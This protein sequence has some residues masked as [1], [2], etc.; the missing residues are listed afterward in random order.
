MQTHHLNEPHAFE[1]T[2]GLRIIFSTEADKTWVGPCKEYTYLVIL[3]YGYG[4][5]MELPDGNFPTPSYKTPA[6]RTPEAQQT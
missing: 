1:L 2:D 3:C 4:K 5:T 6:A